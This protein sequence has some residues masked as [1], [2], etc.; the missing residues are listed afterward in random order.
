LR[1]SI[2]EIERSVLDFLD[3]NERITVRQFGKLANISDRRASRVLIQLVR[4]GVLR[5]HTH[6]KEDFY[7]LAY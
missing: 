4:A 1:I 7:T 3:K 5:I 2:G 6:E